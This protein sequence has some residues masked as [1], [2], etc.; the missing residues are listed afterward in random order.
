MASRHCAA[1]SL[2]IACACVVGM[3]TASPMLAAYA[4][5]ASARRPSSSILARFGEGGPSLP[6][7]FRSSSASVP[8][9]RRNTGSRARLERWTG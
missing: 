5:T 2:D 9:S 7:D 3:S 4:R 8:S 6:S 1:S